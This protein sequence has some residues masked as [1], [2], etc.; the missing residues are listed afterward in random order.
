MWLNDKIKSPEDVPYIPPEEGEHGPTI[1]H[2][3][4]A[5]EGFVRFW[6]FIIIYQV[7][8]SGSKGIVGINVTRLSMDRSS[9]P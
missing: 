1:S 4:P 5:Y 8:D 3:G 6:T 2:R 7:S 9:R